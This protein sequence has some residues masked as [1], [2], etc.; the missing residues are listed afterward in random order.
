MP[1]WV[2]LYLERI[3][4]AEVPLPAAILVLAILATGAAPMIRRAL[5]AERLESH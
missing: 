2:L 4:A 3:A 1:T 5:I